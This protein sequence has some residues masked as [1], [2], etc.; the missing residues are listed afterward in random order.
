MTTDR[1]SWGGGGEG[2]EDS[3]GESHW[4]HITNLSVPS[5]RH[6]EWQK[7]FLSVQ[8]SQQDLDVQ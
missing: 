5:S 4:C 1:K 6:E 3:A 2:K 8:S 7:P